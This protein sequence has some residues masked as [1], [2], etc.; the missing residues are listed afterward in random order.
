MGQER[1]LDFQ[2]ATRGTSLLSEKPQKKI[3][4]FSSISRSCIYPKNCYVLILQT[5]SLTAVR[6]SFLALVALK[7]GA[8]T[9]PTESKCFFGSAFIIIGSI[10]IR[11]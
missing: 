2:R 6:G 8:Q 9:P 1:E 3:Y 11:S 5:V 7:P 10:M 4:F